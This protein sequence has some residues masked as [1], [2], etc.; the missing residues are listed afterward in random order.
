M[1]RRAPVDREPCRC[2]CGC[3]C[4]RAAGAG[5]CYLC[6]EGAHAA[7]D[8]QDRLARLAR[9]GAVLAAATPDSSSGIRRDVLARVAE[10]VG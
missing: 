1:T 6:L 8:R 2:G 4:S 10:A 3:G 5:A 9:Y 7:P